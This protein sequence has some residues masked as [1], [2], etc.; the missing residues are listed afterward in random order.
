MKWS[1]FGRVTMALLSALALGL[2]M[3]ACGGGT[4]AYMWVIGQQYNQI[5]GFKVD[6]YTGNLTSIQKSPFAANGSAPVYILVRP[7]GRYVYVIDQGTGSTSAANSSD[8]GIAI[9]AVGGDGSLVFQ[10]PLVQ[11]AGR[12]HLWAQF[13]ATGNYLYVLDKYSPNGSGNGAITVFSSDANTGRLLLQPQTAFT[14]PVGTAPQFVEVGQNP[15]TMFSTGTCLYT[16]NQQ[17]QTA[18]PYAIGSGQL[19]TV[20]TG[21]IAL[22][23]SNATSINGNSTNVIVTDAGTTTTSTT[24]TTPNPGSIFGF[25]VGAGCALTPYNGSP[26]ANSANTSDP[27][28]SFISGSGKYLYVL[29]A[30][31][32]STATTTP[33]SSIS[34]FI[35]QPSQGNEFSEV[36]G[37]PFPGGAHPVCMVEDPTGQFVY[38]SNHDGGTVSG[39]TYNDTQGPLSPLQRGSTFSTADQQLGCLAI[40]SIVY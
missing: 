9:F 35:F 14:P 30:S 18:T 33:Y 40:S 4:I 38:T 25:T 15:L 1:T 8:S 12:V 27:V 26:Q 7:G 11:S 13:D 5:I 23:T 6:H 32:T 17:D 29:N 3:T 39:F 24:Q 16:V 19:A 10:G 21:K 34:A 36:P 31:T 20:T 22:L 28:Y 2:G 37:Q